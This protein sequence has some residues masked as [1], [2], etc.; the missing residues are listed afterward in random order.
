MATVRIILMAFL[1]FSAG[2]LPSGGGSDGSSGPDSSGLIDVSNPD[3][4]N[5]TIS[6][7]LTWDPPHTRV[8]GERLYAY[9]RGG[10]EIVYQK[11]G[12]D[13][14]LWHSVVVMDDK[15]YVVDEHTLEGLEPGEYTVAIACFDTDG[16]YS[17]FSEPVIVSKGL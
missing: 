11:T 17:D 5:G 16:L 8:N 1:V 12:W 6:L 10:Y 13:P 14:D 7:K 15:S 9:E 2:C 3:Q 4:G